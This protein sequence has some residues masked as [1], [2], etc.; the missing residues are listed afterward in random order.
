M[1]LKKN[2]VGRSV[3]ADQFKLSITGSNASGNTGTTSGSATGLQDAPGA[4]AGPVIAL[5]GASLTLSETGVPGTNLGNYV[6]S[7][8]CTD[9]TGTTL[10]SGSGTSFNFTQ[11][12][13]V[14]GVGAAVTCVFTNTPLTPNLVASKSVDPASGT[15]VQPGQVLTYTLTF[16]NTGGTAPATVS[17]TDWLGD[18]LDASA[19]VAGSI[20]TT[21]SNG[22]PLA[23][24]N[25]SA[26]ATKTLGITGSVAAGAKSVVTYQVTVNNIGNLGDASLENYLTPSTTVTPPTS[27]PP[28][29]TT[30]T[31]NPVGS[32]TLGKTA[33]PASGTT[34]NPGDPATNRVISYTVTAT[35]STANP[36]TGVILTDDLSQ[37]LNNSTFAAGS[38]KL[39]IN[40]GAPVSVPDPGADNKL[41]SASFTLP[42]NGTAVLS[43]SVTV[44]PDAWLVTLRN[45][46]TGNGLIPPV[47]CA[48]GSAMPLNPACVT[49][50]PTSGHLFVQKAGPGATQGSSVPLAGST[51]EI[52]PDSGG[53]MGTT[54]I[55]LGNAV[56]GSTGLIEV[57][58][59]VPGTYWLL[60]TKAPD[61]YSLL[62]TPVKFT[63]AA[64]STIGLDAATAGASVTASGLT[65]TVLDVASV[66]LPSAGG[67]GPS[68]FWGA[69]PLIGILLLLASLILIAY[70]R[71]A[72]TPRTH[73]A[74]RNS[75]H[76]CGENKKGT[77]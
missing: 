19:L 18:V 65:L 8:Q 61:G 30:C 16:D 12:S 14:N 41:V 71:A 58:N 7:Y 74:R 69:A 62:A 77:R 3:T 75:V 70:R 37:V 49:T 13:P 53:Q 76:L 26:A 9:Q 73:I 44:N 6:S 63:L 57:K 2:I 21:T 24:A 60:E 67:P 66:K 34:I 4:V 10:A 56:S 31:V 5:S 40:G 17:Y 1:T 28:G 45:G 46:A 42:G 36:I 51:F 43:Y 47:R 27:C 32:W 59:L 25:N 39:T 48:T 50:H 11:P 72:K 29:T 55:G 15:M 33:S 38:A 68:G 52:R 23:V 35:N 20:T 54:A 64:N 22:T